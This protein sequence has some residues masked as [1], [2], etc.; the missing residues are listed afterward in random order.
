MQMTEEMALLR[1]E[2]E[3]QKMKYKQLNKEYQSKQEEW[4]TIN[5][6]N[7]LTHRQR[8]KEIKRQKRHTETLREDNSTQKIVTSELVADVETTLKK[9]LEH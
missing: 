6:A 9:Q 3:I 1:A 2:I 5:E 4:V 8:N 7:I